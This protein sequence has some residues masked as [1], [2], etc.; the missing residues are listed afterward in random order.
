LAGDPAESR[1]LM[2]P[3]PVDDRIEAILGKYDLWEPDQ[4]RNAV[5]ELAVYL[6][7]LTKEEIKGSLYHQRLTDKVHL[8]NCFMRSDDF[9]SPRD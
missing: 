6:L 4:Y 5:S 1:V 2:Q 7:T 3:T 9:P 8:E